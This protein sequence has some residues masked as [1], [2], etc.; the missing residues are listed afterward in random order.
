MSARCLRQIRASVPVLQGDAKVEVSARMC[1]K[2]DREE[3]RRNRCYS[4]HGPIMEYRTSTKHKE[5]WRGE[6]LFGV[7]YQWNIFLYQFNHGK[8][9]FVSI[10]ISSMPLNCYLLIK[11]KKKSSLLMPLACMSEWL[12]HTRGK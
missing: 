8:F 4:I 11:K 6:L 12:K 9:S 5:K 3:V 10:L 7:T 1:L 2:A